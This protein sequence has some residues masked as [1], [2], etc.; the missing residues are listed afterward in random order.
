MSAFS[1]RSQRGDTLIE[2][3]IGMLL[4]VI[5]GLGMS[6]AA[7]RATVSQRDMNVQQLIVSQMRNLIA[8][9]GVDL[10]TGSLSPITVSGQEITLEADCPSIP[11]NT[12]LGLTA[13]RRVTLATTNAAS[14]FNLGGEITVGN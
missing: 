13:L 3:L 5:V 6:H 12:S 1:K 4:M 9:R 8:S 10:C 11:L 7:A 2:A 14:T